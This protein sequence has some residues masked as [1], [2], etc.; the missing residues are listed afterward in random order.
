MDNNRIGGD[1]NKRREL[2]M[3]KLGIIQEV[4]SLGSPDL[5]RQPSRANDKGHMLITTQ[6]IN[7]FAA[8]IRATVCLEHDGHFSL[9]HTHRERS[10]GNDKEHERV[11]HVCGG[12]SS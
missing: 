11:R 4:R 2:N 5:A 8:S 12:T 9:L 10:G 1:S 3:E 7:H 6:T